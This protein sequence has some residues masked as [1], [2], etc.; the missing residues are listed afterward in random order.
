MRRS[1]SIAVIRIHACLLQ[2]QA[3]PRIFRLQLLVG[4]PACT[5]GCWDLQAAM[6]L[7]RQHM[8]GKQG[9][10][11]QADSASGHLG[12]TKETQNAVFMPWSFL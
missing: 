3:Q 10:H 12:K 1:R 6:L 2:L 11:A 7:V 9:C 4:Q 8:A 5:D